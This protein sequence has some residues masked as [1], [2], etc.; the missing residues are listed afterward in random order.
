MTASYCVVAELNS[1]SN[2]SYVSL[3]VSNDG[4][5]VTKYFAHRSGTVNGL[6]YFAM[7]SKA[8]PLFWPYQSFLPDGVVGPAQILLTASASA[9]PMVSS[10]PSQ[11]TFVPIRR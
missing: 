8:E 3:V 10:L 5:F 4:S 11:R 2:D 1:F 9:L 6:L 7:K